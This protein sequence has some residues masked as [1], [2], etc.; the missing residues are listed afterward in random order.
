MYVLCGLRE[1]G[2]VIDAVACVMVG[3]NVVIVDVEGC[4]CDSLFYGNVP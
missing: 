4:V 3:L 1:C 2:C